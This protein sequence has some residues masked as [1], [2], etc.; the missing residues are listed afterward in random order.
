MWNNLSAGCSNVLMISDVSVVSD[1]DSSS[2]DAKGFTYRVTKEPVGN[3]MSM[4]TKESVANTTAMRKATK[5][6]ICNK[7]TN[8]SRMEKCERLK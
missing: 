4:V 6:S 2:M 5:S 7:H 8:D 3:A 1:A